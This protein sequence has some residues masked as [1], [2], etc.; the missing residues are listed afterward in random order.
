[1]EIN[2]NVTR[3]KFYEISIMY[4]VLNRYFLFEGLNAFWVNVKQEIPF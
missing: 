2:L 4:L 3:L 1:M